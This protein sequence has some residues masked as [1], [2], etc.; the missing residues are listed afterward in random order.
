LCPTELGFTKARLKGQRA[1]VN[2]ERGIV[3]F[4]PGKHPRVD[5]SHLGVGRIACP[6]PRDVDER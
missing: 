3:P 4:V 6:C 2:R 5:Q 1:V